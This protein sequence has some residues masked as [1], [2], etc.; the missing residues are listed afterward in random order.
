[1]SL[2]RETQAQ[3]KT[4]FQSLQD[5]PLEPDDAFYVAIQQQIHPD[6]DPIIEM[7]TSIRW[8]ESSSVHL[9]SGQ[10]GSGKS[11]ELRRLRKLLLPDECDVVLL[12][13]R[14]YMNMTRP[15]E[16]TDFL[17]SVMA[18]LTDAL[19]NVDKDF[20]RDLF[21]T[22]ILDFLSTRMKI[23]A[24]KAELSLGPLKLGL[25]ASLREDPSFKGRLQES[26]RGHVAQVVKQAH[27][28]AVEVVAELRKKTGREDRKLVLLVDSVEQLRAEAAD[29]ASA[30]YKSVE[31][32]FS[33]H[34]AAL[35]IPHV[36][37]VY[38]IPPYLVPLAPSVG[39]VL[40]GGS[41]FTLTSLKVRGRDGQ[42]TSEGLALMERIMQQRH[43][44][45]RTVFT[46]TQL[47]RM[48]LST[49]GDLRDFFRLARNCLVKAASNTKSSLPLA[50]TV[51][52]DSENH[53]RREM[54]PLAEADKKWLR[55]IQKTKKP[56]LEEIDHLPQLA[57]FLD[58]HLVLNYRNGE[59]WYDVH[60]LLWDE[61][62]SDARD[63]SARAD[64]QG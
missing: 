22:R 24:P 3:L 10:R 49:G 12:D 8:S 43:S 2:T 23:D 57:R 7:H 55:R 44:A 28:F 48:A 27:D 42:E 52:S 38:T 25:G 47:H 1:M 39:R 33:G 14:D 5:R 9:L 58:T 29:E 54:L 16:I 50:D 13:M 60:P 18:A 26:L 61:L 64:G 11:T 20:L 21:K 31:E 59:D 56:G 46:Q 45:W 37:M 6:A 4:F 41:I 35:N 36:H 40:G 51:L 63:D 53:L 30:M 17:V 34:A 62:K 15:V 19:E 32:L